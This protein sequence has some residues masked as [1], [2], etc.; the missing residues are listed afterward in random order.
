MRN[1]IQSFPVTTLTP[2][3]RVGI[4]LAL[5]QIAL[6]PAR[7]RNAVIGF[8]FVALGLALLSKG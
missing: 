6:L 5:Q 4:T 3:T 7:Q 1:S 2:A 8:G